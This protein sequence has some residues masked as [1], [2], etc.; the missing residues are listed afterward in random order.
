MYSSIV[1]GELRKL[2]RCSSGRRADLRLIQINEVDDELVRVLRLDTILRYLCGGKIPEV[3]GHD[4][5][6]AGSPPQERAG[7]QGLVTPIL[8]STLVAFHETI[9]HVGVHQL[10][11]PLDLLALE[12]SAYLE[13]APIHSS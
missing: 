10:A 5:A 3:K 1:F 4:D 2:L 12:V 7:R 9:T 6:G 13:Q 8:G 11:C